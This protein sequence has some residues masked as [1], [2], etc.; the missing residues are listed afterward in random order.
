MAELYN[1]LWV[2]GENDFAARV[3]ISDVGGFFSKTL[4]IE[5]GVRTMIL[6]RGQS[7]GEVPPGQYTLQALSER[8]KF[9]TKKAMTAILARQGEVPLELACSGLATSE[10][11]EVEVAV[12]LC[13][14]I[15]DVALF[16]RNLLASRPKLTLED[17]KEIIQP[18]IRQALWETIGR[19]SIKDLTGEQARGDLELCISQ[20]LGT[21][22]FRNGLKFTQVQALSV[23]HPE[24]D[25]HRERTG[26]LWLQRLGL[27]HERSEA[28]LAADRLLQEIQQQ[29]KTDELEVLA[30]QVA[31]DRM[32]GDLAA[33]IRRIG[34]R[35]QI[36]AAILAG[37]FDGIQSEEERLRF[38]Q[39]RDTE[40]LIRED[41]YQTL[42]ETLNNQTEDREATRQQLLR[43]LQLEQNSEQETLRVEL[44][45]AQQMRTRRHEIAL[46][47]LNDSEETRQWRLEIEREASLA[48]TRRVEA[49]K[50]IE[51]D[52]KLASA[53]KTDRREEE[54]L[55]TIHAQRLDRAQGEI[56]LAQAER[57]QRAGLIE[58][59][60]RKSRELS[61]LDLQ[62]RKAELER[63]IN[64]NASNDQL[65]K[66]MKIQEMNLAMAKAQHELKLMEQRQQVELESMR[67][68]KQSESQLKRI[69][70]MRGMS[71]IELVAHS[72]NAAI[73]AE[74]L[75]H[76]SSQHAT[77]EVAK[78]QAAA[79]QATNS[80]HE[81]MYQKLNDA[82]RQNAD[83]VIA[84]MREAM[85]GQQTSFQ[86]FGSIIEGV[87][88]NLAPQPNSTV[89]VSGGAAVPVAP[90]G[91]THPAPHRA[92][93]C[94][95]C[96]SEN[97]DTARFCHQC[98]KPL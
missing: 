77:V 9:W 15:D 31:A 28:Q 54:W 84:A 58:I 6:E 22:L 69:Q 26:Q 10:L 61:E 53:I 29:E 66:L 17:L 32:E 44:D 36:R 38:L 85:M 52:R 59:E 64:N 55:E 70:A 81:E 5:P 50:Q 42:V 47:E 95:S 18:I 35:K 78:A 93:V 98:G 43:R 23:S 92:L 48:E 11:L 2:A 1:N 49:L 90:A 4:T 71:E 30:Q 51:H 74:T 8:L 56:Q 39:Q 68:D 96:R 80:K 63:E 91:A 87:T 41:E 89:V 7:V 75:K 46:T 27:D 12:R 62:S 14:Q 76:Q 73:V 19:L 83:R 45:Y 88:R 67:E 65:T 13:L 86:Q 37:E 34:I 33:K 97:A 20:S 40:R 94:S 82:E 24:Y 16:Q 25:A 72:P 3:E 57:A 79:L 60:M 21:A